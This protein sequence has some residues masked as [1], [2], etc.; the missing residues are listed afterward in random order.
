MRNMPVP[1]GITR[2]IF[3]NA[4]AGTLVILRMLGQVRKGQCQFVRLMSLGLRFVRGLLLLL[5]GFFRPGRHNAVHARVSNGLAEVFAEVPGDCDE[6]TAERGRAVEHLLR[7]VSIG[8][9]ERND[10]RAEMCEGIL[11]G[12]QHLWLI[13]PTT[14]VAFQI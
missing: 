12:L 3:T 4:V 5:L 6:I 9:A 13:S 14:P 10:S 7:F 1:E 11:Q 8:L 2:A